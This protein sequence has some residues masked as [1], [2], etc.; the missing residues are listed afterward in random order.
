MLILMV[1]SRVRLPVVMM[2]LTLLLR[3]LMV[4]LVRWNLLPFRGIWSFPRFL[5]GILWRAGGSGGG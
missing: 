3:P 5:N 4:G 1:L 2:L